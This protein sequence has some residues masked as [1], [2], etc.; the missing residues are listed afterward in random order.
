[1]SRETTQQELVWMSPEEYESS[2]GGQ[3]DIQLEDANHTK[4]PRLDL[5][6][7]LIKNGTF[8]L[9]ISHNNIGHLMSNIIISVI[10]YSVET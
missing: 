5:P 10:R 8:Y 3:E 2:G 6:A 7:I 9:F 4:L 1:M